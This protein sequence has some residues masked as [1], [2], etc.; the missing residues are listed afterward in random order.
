MDGGFKI[1]HGP[2]GSI[3]GIALLTRGISNAFR[4][5][6]G[7]QQAG[8]E[9]AAVLG[10]TRAETADLS[11]EAIRLGSITAKTATEVTQLQQAFARLGF[12]QGEILNLTGATISGSIAMN[13]E[14]A[15]TAELVGAVVNS[16]D[17]FSSLDASEIIDQLS[18]STSKSALNFE[19]L[20]T[21]LPIVSGA[22]N[23]AGVPFTE[24]LALLG[25]LSDAGIDASTSATALRNIFIESA[26]QGRDYKDLLGDVAGSTDKLTKSNELF[27]KK[28]AVQAV[29]LSK[30][31]DLV[32]DLDGVLRDAGGTAQQMADEQLNTLSGSLTLLSSAWDGMILSFENGEGAFGKAIKL[33]IDDMTALLGSIT[34]TNSASAELEQLLGRGYWGDG[35]IDPFD[36]KTLLDFNFAL[37]RTRDLWREMSIEDLSS[38]WADLSDEMHRLDLNTE[39][40]ADKAKL[41]ANQI[42]LIKE[43]IEEKRTAE[44]N[45]ELERM[46][47]A[48]KDAASAIQIQAHALEQLI[49][50]LKQNKEQREALVSLNNSPGEEAHLERLRAEGRELEKQIDLLKQKASLDSF[51]GS[52]AVE[53]MKTVQLNAQTRTEI[54]LAEQER[55]LLSERDLLELYLQGNLITHQEYLRQRR[56]LDQDDKNLAIINSRAPI[57][58]GAPG[59]SNGSTAGGDPLNQFFGAASSKLNGTDPDLTAQRIAAAETYVNTLGEL[60]SAYISGVENRENRAFDQEVARNNAKKEQLQQR[61]NQ[62]VIDQSV[63]ETEVRKIEEKENSKKAALQRKQ[64]KRQQKADA[65]MAGIQGSLAIV[66]AIAQFGPPPSPAGIAGIISAGLITGLNVATILSKP[67]PQFETGGSFST[68]SGVVSGAS[69]SSGGISMIDSLTGQKVGEMEGGEMYHIYSKDTVKQN[70]PM[71]DA[72]LNSSMYGGGRSVNFLSSGNGS[73]GGYFEDGGAV[74][75][76]GADFNPMINEMKGMREDLRGLKNIRATVVA[77]EVRTSLNRKDEADRMSGG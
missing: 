11:K 45:S 67:V 44:Y 17:N 19:K 55:Q 38:Q 4:T 9:L 33:M 71:M 47:A 28:G 76:G 41:L 39:V 59:V 16:F 36:Y 48:S 35:L 43:I 27:G 26:A 30:N 3:G 1:N 60:H 72:L 62:G 31:I 54:Y 5:I 7:F 14:L 24:L 23:A 51:S 20:Q 57:S 52:G 70:R 68:D 66:K 42:K 2:S 74:V 12:S 13:G 6:T 65:I 73:P 69:H 8:A 34:G 58:G 75:A 37:I 22:A 40:G 56:L 50:K 25:K 32:K 15:S 49:E 10:K 63:Y 53:M 18:L 61:L 64:F 21:S 29:I 46:A 77:E